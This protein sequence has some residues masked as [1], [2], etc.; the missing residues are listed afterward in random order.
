[1]IW[2]RKSRAD[3]IGIVASPALAETPKCLPPFPA[4]ASPFLPA[5]SL[6]LDGQDA[7]LRLSFTSLYL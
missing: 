3:V 1:M 5:A 2:R 4:A 7:G 6:T